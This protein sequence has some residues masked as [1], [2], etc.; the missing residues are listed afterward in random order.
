MF[1]LKALIEL[2]FVIFQ[3]TNQIKRV[4]KNFEF[5]KNRPLGIISK[6]KFSRDK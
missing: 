3:K 6:A 1:E 5:Y 2:I 4:L